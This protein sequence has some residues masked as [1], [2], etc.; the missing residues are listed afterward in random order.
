MEIRLREMIDENLMIDRT[1]VTRTVSES[2]S[3]SVFDSE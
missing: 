3:E 1:L 2:E